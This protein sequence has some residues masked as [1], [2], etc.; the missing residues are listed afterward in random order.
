MDRVIHPLLSREEA[1]T[2][3]YCPYK[4]KYELVDWLISFTD[5]FT[6]A[7]ANRLSIKQLY[8]FYYNPHKII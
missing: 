1:I 3:S 6:K 7:E 5:R 4:Y 2:M 8:Y